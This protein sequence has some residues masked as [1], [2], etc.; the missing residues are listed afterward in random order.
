MEMV[1]SPLIAHRV[2]QLLWPSWA[3]KEMCRSSS[4]WAAAER[5][6]VRVELVLEPIFRR[7]S[8]AAPVVIAH[9]HNARLIHKYYPMILSRPSNGLQLNEPTLITDKTQL[10]ILSRLNLFG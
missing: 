2:G 5:S 8:D 10:D 9:Q 3:G 4:Y 1:S 6:A 7:L